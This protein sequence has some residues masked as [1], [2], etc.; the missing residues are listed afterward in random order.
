LEKFVSRSE[1]MRRNR[2]WTTVAVLGAVLSSGNLGC[3][4]GAL[5]LHDWQRDL[6]SLLGGS[7]LGPL[8]G[9]VLGG[10]STTNILVERNCFENG[11]QVDCSTIPQ[12]ND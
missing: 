5:N 12:A 6:L 8:V 4:P 7:L 10:D 9:G 11:V 1:T 2:K 3:T